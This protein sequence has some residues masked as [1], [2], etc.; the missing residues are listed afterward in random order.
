MGS[1]NSKVQCILRPGQSGKTRKMV[2]L[3]KDIRKE[4]AAA[5]TAGWSEAGML[6]IFIVS[7]VMALADQTTKR[8]QKELADDASINSADSDDDINADD[9]VEGD[10]FSWISGNRGNRV[11]ANALFSL[12]VRKKV[13]TVVLCANKRRLQYLKSLIDMLNEFPHFHDNIHIWIDEADASINLWSKKQMDVTDMPVVRRV[14]LVSATFNSILKQYGRLHMLGDIITH[15]S[16]YHKVADCT[17]IE[18][19]CAFLPSEYSGARAYLSAVLPRHPEMCVPGVRL[20]APG[21]YTQDSH[22]EVASYL[23]SLGFAI[24]VL[25]GTEKVIRLPN[26]CD[27][28]VLDFRPERTDE[29]PKRPHAI[30][31][32]EEIG[33]YVARLYKDNGL[34][35]FPFAVTGHLCIGRGL[36]FQNKDFLFDFGILPFI[37]NDAM[38]YQAACRMAGN[39]RGLLGY[40]IAT[41][42][43]TSR[44]WNVVRR[45]EGFAV[46][47][48]RI[49]KERNL[50]DVGVEEFN[51]AGGVIE[52]PSV[53]DYGLSPTFDTSEAAAAWCDEKL[54]YG[55]SVY[56]LYAAEGNA[57][58]THIKYRGALRSILTEDELRCSVP[59]THHE[60]G[61]YARVMPVDIRWGIADAARVMP[62][63][64]QPT[65]KWVAIFKKDK[66][67][68][69]KV[70]NFFGRRPGSVA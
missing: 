5:V 65:L 36:T 44:M 45:Q 15:P 55:K 50:A 59:A 27:S 3:I 42:V 23:V 25:N 7:N 31:P 22:D 41:L 6:N 60:G 35:Q 2:D 56:G 46:N 30:K 52:L 39:I 29:K 53:R 62:L 34:E 51:E 48:A 16:L 28:I 63:N 17:V 12:I 43:T 49:V 67:R 8:M 13:S 19:D 24:L 10:C 64:T 68:A 47:L 21:D 20:F 61:A 26:R 38:A 18:D 32:D 37:R 58:L 57:G 33:E 54:T 14:T 9:R 40:K 69:F 11:D 1:S 66:L 70:A 4:Y